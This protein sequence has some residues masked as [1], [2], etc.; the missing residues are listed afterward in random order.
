MPVY[1]LNGQAPDLPAKGRYF[2]APGAQ[3]IGRV[4]LGEDAGVWFGAVL[5]GDGEPIAIGRRSNV[6]DCAIL[7]TDIGYP[8]SVGANCTIGHAAILHGC[9]IEDTCLI[10][11]AATASALV[12]EG[13]EFPP[14]SL[15]VGSPARLARALD[16]AAEAV[17]LAAAERY[18]RNWQ[19]YARGLAVLEG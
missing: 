6:Q 19:S 11:M 8:L 9:T 1:A 7:H 2:V 14:R 15:I 12:T 18:V 5:R 17:I 10:G 4:R 16:D 3:V 13:K